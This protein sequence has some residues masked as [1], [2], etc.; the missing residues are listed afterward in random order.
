MF[1]REKYFKKMFGLWAA[2]H[3]ADIVVIP[4]KIIVLS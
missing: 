2:P 1:S 3:F 4:T